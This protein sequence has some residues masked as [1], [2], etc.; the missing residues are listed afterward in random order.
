MY[1][2]LSGC[3]YAVATVSFY[4]CV[5]SVSLAGT[6][7]MQT[8]L[9]SDISGLAAVTDPNL[10]NPWG[11][12][13]TPTSPF[14]VS[15]QVKN[16]ATLYNASGAPQGGP[17]IVNTPGGPT[18]QAF[19]STSGFL[20]GSTAATFIF[21]TLAGNIE[22]WNGAQG[23]TAMIMHT[24]TPGAYT[25]LALLGNQLFAANKA[26]GNIDVFDSSFNP[27]S[28]PGTAFA[29]PPGAGSLTP[30]NI[31]T[32]NGNLWVEY[33]GAR[34]APGGFV[35]EFDSTGKLL[36]TISDAHLN[37]PWGIT[38]APPTF[39]TF[40]GD[41]LI[42]NFN[43]GMINAFDPTNGFAF[44]G[45]LSDPSGNP[46]A[47]P[48]LWALEFRDTSTPNGNTGSNPNTLFFSAGIGH[49]SDG[50]ETHGL[51]AEVNAVPEPG[52]SALVALAGCALIL[53]RKYRR[54]ERR[55]ADA[56]NTTL[57]AN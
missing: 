7:F 31:Q 10:V 18:G 4:L 1:A 29:T 55:V 8:N 57:S 50:V 54:A 23:T 24:T 52:T 19:N 16:V 27:V 39:G 41:L 32:I 53:L 13:F 17:L 30:Y 46:I 47:N 38:L 34:L 36:Q 15:D 35:A 11:V 9:V 48:G 25:G 42:G 49:G 12:S 2:L 5:S 3:R 6:V 14:W 26:T 21:A 33:S 22:A 40:G 43:D 44:A 45:T 56:Q 37:A 28:L 20:I 51:F